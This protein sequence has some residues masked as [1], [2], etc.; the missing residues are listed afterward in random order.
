MLVR[1]VALWLKLGGCQRRS[2]GVSRAGLVSAEP[3]VDGG[4]STSPA[5]TVEVS[6]P[7]F[8]TTQGTP[9][10]RAGTHRRQQG[11]APRLQVPMCSIIQ[12]L[13]IQYLKLICFLRQLFK[14]F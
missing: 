11:R 8:S 1:A 2:W 13:L 10:P 7:T 5:P 9:L 3:E 12:Q 14:I 4:A 6:H